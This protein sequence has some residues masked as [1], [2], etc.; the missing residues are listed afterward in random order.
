[1]NKFLLRLSLVFLAWLDMSAI[2]ADG[3]IRTMSGGFFVK[4]SESSAG[5]EVGKGDTLTAGPDAWSV[6]VMDDGTIMNLKSDSRI[7]IADYAYD[8]EDP[9]SNAFDIEL[10]I[11]TLRF[12]SGFI[13]E[14]DPTDATIRIG[15]TTLTFQGSE[16]EVSF[17]GVEVVVKVLS[18]DWVANHFNG[19]SCSAG[20][21]EQIRMNNETGHCGIETMPTEER[22]GGEQGGGQTAILSSEAPAERGENVLSPAPPPE[23][24]PAPSI[25]DPAIP[26]G[27]SRT[28]SQDPF[29]GQDLG[30]D[31]PTGP[32]PPV[33][34]DPNVGN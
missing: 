18:G 16:M 31:P 20:A 26:P 13:G 33:T 19:S 27:Q 29:T 1:M 5:K 17:D 6:V 32:E 7:I 2:A 9:K 22:P 14:L 10:I 25:P 15:K 8:P 34:N 12:V 11:G 28:F 23:P 3:V 21:G 24:I 30:G 4:T